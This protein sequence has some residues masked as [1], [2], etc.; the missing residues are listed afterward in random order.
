MFHQMYEKMRM[1][2]IWLKKIQ[3]FVFQLIVTYLE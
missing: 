2:I 1:K 3:H